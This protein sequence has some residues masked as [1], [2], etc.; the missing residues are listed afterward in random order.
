TT[1]YMRSIGG[2][3]LTL[4]CGQHEDPAAPEVAYRAIVNTLVHLGLTDAPDPPPVRMESLSLCEVT[5]R[6]HP[7]ESFVQ[8]WRSFDP[9]AQGQTIGTRHDGSVLVAPFTGFIVFPNP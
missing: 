4:E 2:S 1:E 3:A 7:Q 8:A 6:L 5:D 9:V